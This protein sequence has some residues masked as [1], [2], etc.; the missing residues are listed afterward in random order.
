MERLL[1]Q[2]ASALDM[3]ECYIIYKGAV[4]EAAGTTFVVLA[5]NFLFC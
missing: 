5:R 1:F 2:M 4:D 3:T